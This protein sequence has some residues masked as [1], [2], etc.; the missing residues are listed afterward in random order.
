MGLPVLVLGESGSGKSSS[1]RNFDKKDVLVFSVAGKRLPFRKK[2]Q[3]INLRNMNGSERYEVITMYLNKYQ[4]QCKTFV[5]D[6]S[7]YLMAFEELGRWAEKGY[8]KFSQMALHFKDLLDTIAALDDDVIVYL[9]HHTEL[10]DYGRLRAKTTGKMLDSKL[11]VEGLFEI[12]LLAECVD[13]TYIFNTHNDG[14]ATTKSPIGMFEDDTIENDLKH[15]NDVIR[16][17]Y[18]NE[19]E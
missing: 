8:E 6:D 18:M 15:V 14:R 13:G 19:E 4:K 17:Y 2:L 10:D 12:V 5:I 7:Q 16:S 3:T 11:T 1:L 9:L